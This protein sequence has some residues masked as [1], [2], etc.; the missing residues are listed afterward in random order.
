MRGISCCLLAASFF[1]AGCGEGRRCEDRQGSY[2]AK[3]NEVSGDCHVFP[4]EI[5]LYAEGNGG[6]RFI[7]TEGD[8]TGGIW[9]SEDNCVE[10]ID[11]TCPSTTIRGTTRYNGKR[12]WSEDGYYCTE[13]LEYTEWNE[14]GSVKCSSK[15]EITIEK[16]EIP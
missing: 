1:A 15:Y 2:L 8:C 5:N 13:N 3:Y 10:T 16:V 7:P 4:D 9:I 11:V 14:D 6:E 12:E